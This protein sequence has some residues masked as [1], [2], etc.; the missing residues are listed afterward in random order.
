MPKITKIEATSNSRSINSNLIRRKK[1][2]AYARVSTD[3]DEQFTSFEAQKDYYEKLIL[4]KP[5]WEY[6][7]VYADE[8]ISGT[9]TKNREGFTS[10]IQDALNGKIDLIVTKS[11]SRFARN[12]VDTLS[13]IR[14]LKEKGVEVYFEK[15]NIYTMNG[16]G[17][18]LITIM[19]SLAQEESRS[20]SENVKW[21]QR[22]SFS[23]GKVHL[24]YSRFLGY[25]KGEDGKPEIVPE[26]AE[27]VRL[28]YSKFMEGASI[29]A[30]SA[31]LTEKGIKTPGGKDKWPY[32][33]I[34]SILK[35][36]KYK[37]DALLQKA[38]VEN[39]LTHKTVKNNGEVPQYY[40]EGSHKAIISPAEWDLVQL[41][42]KR[43]EKF[44]KSYS[45]SGI[46]SNRIVCSDCGSF[47]GPKVWHSNDKYRAIIW[48][49][50]SKFGK[51]HEKCHTIH[52]TESQII[53][54]FLKAYNE[55]GKNKAN[56]VEDCQFMIGLI[57][58]TSE[59]SEK[60]ESINEEIEVVVEMVEKLIKEN[61]SKPQD[62]DE[63]MKK[64]NSLEKRHSALV[65]KVTTLELERKRK[66]EQINALNIYLEAYKKQPE[67]VAE[68]DPS[69]WIMTVDQVLV[70]RN[71]KIRFKFYTGAEIEVT[72]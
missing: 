26:E 6:V 69:I 30:I 27:I 21:G 45:G 64:H 15:E 56:V 19:S 57:N 44:K 9:N 36:E 62:Q 46:F 23:D 61:M 37:G 25:R 51:N 59:L 72:L 32:S 20:L 28:I 35:N 70:Q 38:Y 71:G 42:F 65:E 53:N 16:S 17:E 34:I 60:I 14:K 63:Y 33:T 67:F 66:L 29:S 41:E 48:Q 8:G 49:C 47:Y 24:P 18:L 52:L 58:N 50:N 13:T 12:T 22:K 54:C 1:V 4:A 55:L 7:K 10:M 3:S 43:R 40:V 31:L 68:W 39:F 11:V 5:E 2:C